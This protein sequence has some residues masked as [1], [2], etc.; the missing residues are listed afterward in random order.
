MC[1]A[2]CKQT[3]SLTAGAGSATRSNQRQTKVKKTS[4]IPK[5]KK[6]SLKKTKNKKKNQSVS[7]QLS[8]PS[9][10]SRTIDYD[11]MVI[12]VSSN[13]SY[14]NYVSPIKIVNSSNSELPNNTACKTSGYGYTKH[15]SSG[16][17][18]I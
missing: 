7:N 13:W 8:H 2:H 5:I 1:A 12:T 4:S 17:P 16:N 14:D 3:G 9:Y 18:G 15:N 11:Y 6:K 10:N